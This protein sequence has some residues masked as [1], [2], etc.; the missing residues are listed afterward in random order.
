MKRISRDP[1]ARRPLRTV[2]ALLLLLGLGL[3]AIST[4]QAQYEIK[5]GVY[6]RLS[7]RVNAANP[8][9][10]GPAGAPTGAP[11]ITP[12]FSNVVEGSGAASR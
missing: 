4:S 2:P 12:Q 6:N 11:T 7:N 3:G 9:P 8:T 5:S 10:V 1:G